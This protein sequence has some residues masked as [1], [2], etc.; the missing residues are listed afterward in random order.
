MIRVLYNPDEF[1]RRLETGFFIPVLIVSL[2]GIIGSIISYLKIGEI[3]AYLTQ[4]LSEK[5][6][7]E[8]VRIVIEIV[9]VQTIIS[10]FLSAFISWIIIAAVLHGL[11]SIFGGKNGFS[12]T[13]KFTSF[14]FLPFIVLSPLD[15]Y[16]FS[17]RPAIHLTIFSIAKT[18]W[19]AN[20]LV[21]AVKHSRDIDLKRSI[22]CVL[23]P[24]SM[25]I[26]ISIYSLLTFQQFRMFKGF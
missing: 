23:I 11:S 1:F 22:I 24:T 13:L 15:F 10:P 19:Q 26:A 21:F 18:V 12:R 20:I 25:L 17:F 2:S 3:E 9:R 16:L 14:S 6:T 4:I 7:V 5:L 8:Q